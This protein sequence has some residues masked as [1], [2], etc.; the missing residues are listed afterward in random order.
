MFRHISKLMC[1]KECCTLIYCYI[2]IKWPQLNRKKM[3]FSNKLFLR[4]YVQNWI[5]R[6]LQNVKADMPLPQT[7]T[8]WIKFL[9]LCEDIG[10]KK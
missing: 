10:E 3:E 4:M 7:R 1:F 5:V 8:I 2:F 6:P 9:F